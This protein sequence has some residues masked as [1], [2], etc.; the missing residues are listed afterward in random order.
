MK[1]YRVAV[2]PLTINGAEPPFEWVYP[3]IE[4][5]SEHDAVEAVMLLVQ[6]DHPEEKLEGYRPALLMAQINNGPW[7][8]MWWAIHSFARLDDEDRRIRE[9]GGSSAVQEILRFPRREE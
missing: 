3:A 2:K 5:A 6:L 8:R 4:A 9:R 7:M 1:T